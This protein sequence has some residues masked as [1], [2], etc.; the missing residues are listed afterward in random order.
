MSTIYRCENIAKLILRVTVGLL[1]LFHGIAK[2]T[3]LQSLGFIK[4]QLESIGMNTIFAYGVYIGEIVAPLLIILGIY[5]RFGGFL[6]FVN[7]LFAIILVHMNDLLALTE[8]GG[9][10]LELQAFYL[11]SGLVIML[12]GSGK[13]AIKPD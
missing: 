1:M 4:S 6:I 7:M 3:N 8:H 11:V 9:W 13:L 10:V 2:L 5:S 12:I